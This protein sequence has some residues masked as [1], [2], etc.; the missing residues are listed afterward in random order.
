MAMTM[1]KSPSQ[2]DAEIANA[3]SSRYYS[4]MRYYSSLD[5]RRTLRAGT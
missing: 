3:L 5:V 1:T 2:L 4:V